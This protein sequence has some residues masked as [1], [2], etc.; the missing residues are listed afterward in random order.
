MQ[1]NRKTKYS[2][3]KVGF[4]EMTNKLDRL[5]ATMTKKKIRDNA[6]K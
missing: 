4:F 5:L 2:K 3:K 1:E 6:Y